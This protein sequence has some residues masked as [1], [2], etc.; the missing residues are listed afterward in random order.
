M[1]HIESIGNNIY[2]YW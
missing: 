2:Y 1:L